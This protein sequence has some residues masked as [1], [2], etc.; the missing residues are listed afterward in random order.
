MYSPLPPGLPPPPHDAWSE[1]RRRAYLLAAPLAVLACVA[2]LLAQVPRINRLDLVMLTLLALSITGLGTALWR[3]RLSVGAAMGS[4]YLLTAVY[5]LAALQQQY[6][7]DVG[8]TQ[9]LS[10][11]VY[12]FPALYC[13]AY[14]AW[15]LRPATLAAVS[16]VAAALLI[17][18]LN[19]PRLLTQ[20]HWSQALAGILIQFCLSQVVMVAL[21]YGFAYLKQRYVEL[22]SLAYADV[23]TGLPNRRYIE[24][25]MGASVDPPASPLALLTFDVDHFKAINDTYGHETGDV[26]LRE[27]AQLAQAT[28]ARPALLGAPLPGTVLARWGGEEFVVLLPGQN[29]AQATLLAERLRGAFETHDWGAVGRVTASFGTAEGEAGSFTKT[30]RRADFAMYAA[31]TGGRNRVVSAS[32]PAPDRSGP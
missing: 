18:G 7:L 22:Q 29:E 25:R 14:L 17:T 10:E 32:R 6:L 2:G 31:K 30:L 13:L 8:P 11:A 16:T 9:H 24:E 4:V 20:G 1:L 21:L 5:L 12:W 3:R 27:L 26:V 19:L 23:L 15:E 28:L